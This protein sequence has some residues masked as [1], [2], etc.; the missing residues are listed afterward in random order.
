MLRNYK[1]IIWD[2]NGTLLNDVSLCIEVMNGML[3]KRNLPAISA[4]TYQ[5]IFCFPIYRYYEKLGFDFDVEPFETLAVEYVS[6]FDERSKA[7]ELHIGAVETL[8]SLKLNGRRQFI[9]SAH[10]HESLLD[11]LSSHDLRKYFDGIYGIEN[12]EAGSKIHRGKVLIK[13]HNLNPEETV[14]IGD[15]DHD[16]EVADELG[17]SCILIS[18]GHNSHH[19][20][21]SLHSAV[22]PTL[23]NVTS[24][25]EQ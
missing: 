14:L 12:C 2:W 16:L 10:E 24:S 20:L 25:F 8:G 15:T 6:E 19:R 5:D 3:A 11:V 18:N 17:I 9:L 1:N 7:C 22:Y 13:E 4:E 21:T 23:A